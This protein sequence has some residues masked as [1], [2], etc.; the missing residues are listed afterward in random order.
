M[1]KPDVALEGL[2]GRMVKG[3]EGAFAEFHDAYFSRLFRYAL[4]LMRGDEHAARDVTQETLLRV[5]RYVRVFR[6][7]QTFWDWLARLARTAAAD[8]L[9]S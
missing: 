8:Q 2:T 9:G 1:D 7:E 3:E 4:V 6:S 5:V